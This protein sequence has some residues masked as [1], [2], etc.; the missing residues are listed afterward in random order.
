MIS[1]TLG[2]QAIQGRLRG[3]EITFT[4]GNTKYAGT[5]E[6]NTMKITSP[7]AFTATKK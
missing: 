7:T 1:G 5:V 6:G 3:N 4:A 2:S